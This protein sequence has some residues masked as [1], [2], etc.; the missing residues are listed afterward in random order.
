MAA[1][2]I[3]EDEHFEYLREQK[4]S[5]RDLA[6][7]RDA[8]LNAYRHK[9]DV[10]FAGLLPHLP[11]NCGS[12]LDIGGGLGGIDV[13]LVRRFGVDCEVCILDGVADLPMMYLHRQTFNNMAVTRDFLSK[14]GVKNFSYRTPEHPG[15]PRPFDLIISTGSW[16]FHYPPETYL[17]FVKACCHAGTV[18]IVDIRKHKAGWLKT[19]KQSFRARAVAKSQTKFD[20]MVFSVNENYSSQLGVAGVSSTSHAEAQP[21]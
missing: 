14:N 18:L 1:A 8:W 16:C 15:L 21:G 10:D 4:G 2:L 11:N 5:I 7:N 9:L 19:M 13:A 6:P 17:E 12:I 3:V 20:R